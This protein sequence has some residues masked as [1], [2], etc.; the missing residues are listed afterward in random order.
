MKKFMLKGLSTLM[1]MGFS[2]SSFA[3]DM[4]LEE[5][6]AKVLEDN[7]DIKIQYENYYQAQKSIGVALG[8]FLPR[9]GPNLLFT[10]NTYG[11]LVSV[12]PTPSSWFEYEA[13]KDLSRAEK[14]TTTSIKLNILKGLTDTYIDIKKNERTLL[15][16]EKQEVLLQEVYDEAVIR[17]ELGIGSEDE[18][19]LADRRLRQLRQDIYYVK[20]AVV[21]QKEGL[22][23]ALNQDPAQDLDLSNLPEISLNIPETIEEAQKHAL[24]NSTELISNFYLAQAAKDMKKSAKWSFVS[25]SGIGFGYPSALSISKSSA[26]VI[27]LKRQKIENEINNQVFSAYKELEIIES[28][29]ENQDSIVELVENN[30]ERQA[31]L[32]EGGVITL[33]KYVDAQ[34]NVLV[35]KR[36]LNELTSLKRSTLSLI[37]RLLNMDASLTQLD[38]DRYENADLAVQTLKVSK[39]KAVYSITLDMDKLRLTNIYAINYSVEGLFNG[40]SLEI[41]NTESGF[42]YI[43]KVKEAGVYTINAEILLMNGKTINKQVTVKF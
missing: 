13:S 26:R 14:Y 24:D 34:I 4:S 25:F 43:L 9:I 2:I 37:R 21:A 23:I 35:E 6:R 38:M 12:V 15:S 28:R 11:L 22:L 33:S 16:L 8:N 41:S 27:E 17:E 18:V 31:D 39:R 30:L 19:F 40:Q 36:K 20:S 32:Y 5:L 10:N 3:V 7:L 42:E 1:V 29:L